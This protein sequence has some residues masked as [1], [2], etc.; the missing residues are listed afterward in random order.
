MQRI[1]SEISG[2]VFSLPWMLARDAGLFRAQG[3]EMEFV[4]TR[5]ARDV[6][7]TDDP[8][9]VDPVL[10]HTAFPEAHA[11]LYRA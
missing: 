3:L 8:E 7:R 6:T 4:F 5:P 10:A 9:E 2:A 1:V 11:S